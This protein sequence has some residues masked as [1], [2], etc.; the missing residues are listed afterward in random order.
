MFGFSLAEVVVILTVA[1]IVLGPDQLPKVARSLAKVYGHL[2]RFKAEFTKT[3]EET[4]VPLDTSKWPEDRSSLEIKPQDQNETPAQAENLELERAPLSKD[5]SPDI[6][7]NLESS[8]NN[9]QINQE[10]QTLET[11]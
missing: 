9:C 4:M 6:D 3:I 11:K 2:A 7:P 1:L 5:Q 8:P 10:A